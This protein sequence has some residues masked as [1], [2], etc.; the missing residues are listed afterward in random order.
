MQLNEFLICNSD[1]LLAGLQELKWSEEVSTVENWANIRPVFSVHCTW[2][3]VHCT[4][5]STE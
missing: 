4:L 1:L 5:Y 3:I 2:H